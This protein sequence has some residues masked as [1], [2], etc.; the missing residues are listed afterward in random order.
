METRTP[1]S[2]SGLQKRTG[3]NTGTALRADSTTRAQLR[4]TDIDGM[5]ITAF[6]TDTAPGAVPGQLAG[7]ELRHRQHARVEDRI[8]E[9]KA[10]GLVNLP[11][12][13]FDA[14]AAWLEIVLA[15]ADLVA[16]AQLIGF[17]D[18]RSWPAAK[19][20]LSATGCC[21]SRPAS[22]AAPANDGYA[23]TPP[24]AG[25]TPSPPPGSASAPPS[26]PTDPRP[27][28]PKDPLATGKPC[29]TWRHGPAEH[30]QPRK[31]YRSAASSAQ[32]PRTLTGTKIEAREPIGA[33]VNCSVIIGDVQRLPI[34][35]F[36]SSHSQALN[37]GSNSSICRSRFSGLLCCRRRRR[38]QRSRWFDR[39]PDGRPLRA[40]R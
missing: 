9:A 11:C 29:P 30:T 18:A 35:I 21:T 25:P 19:S 37:L 10:A 32:H 15:A 16:W 28:D 1:G 38:S 7:L 24:G 20:L 34:R 12:H 40:L 14:N 2:A 13:G 8:R 4:F 6:I 33:T 23:S 5:R 39:L 17:A 36:G 31:R 22:P 3:G 27:D 26:Q